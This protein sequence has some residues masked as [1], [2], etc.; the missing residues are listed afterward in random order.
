VAEKS[1][2]AESN[3]AIRH[4]MDSGRRETIGTVRSAKEGGGV[5]DFRDA[6]RIGM[7]A[8]MGQ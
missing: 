3:R 7:A 2:A 8:T 5:P 6:R 1:I 4:A